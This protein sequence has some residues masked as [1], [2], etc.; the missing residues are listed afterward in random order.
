[1]EVVPEVS[2]AEIWILAEV[3]FWRKGFLTKAYR[4][5]G[6]MPS[7][8]AI[9]DITKIGCMKEEFPP[10]VLVIGRRKIRNLDRI[11]TVRSHTGI[12]CPPFLEVAG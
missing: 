1:M 2:K 9:T 3:S 5:R 10:L 6:P 12:L 8:Y 11:K 4:T 7:K